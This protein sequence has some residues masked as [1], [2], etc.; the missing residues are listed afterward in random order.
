V[1]N[2]ADDELNDEKEKMIRA[3]SNSHKKGL[4]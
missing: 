4:R 1:L 2:L 3:A